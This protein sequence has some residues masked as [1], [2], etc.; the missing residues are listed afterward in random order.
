MQLQ[1]WLLLYHLS[2]AEWP[3]DEDE[4]YKEEGNRE[5]NDRRSQATL[6]MEQCLEGT[7]RLE[8]PVS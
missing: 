3:R 1:S 5:K 8:E 4:H 2:V 6:K 7:H